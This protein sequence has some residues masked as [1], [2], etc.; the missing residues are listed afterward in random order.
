MQFRARQS[1]QYKLQNTGYN[2]EINHTEIRPVWHEIYPDNTMECLLEVAPT[3]IIGVDANNS[4]VEQDKKLAK[5]NLAWYGK[6]ITLLSRI[7]DAILI[8]DYP[9]PIPYTTAG[10]ILF[11][12]FLNGIVDEF[13]LD[14]PFPPFTRYTDMLYPSPTPLA[15]HWRKKCI[16]WL[17]RYL[18][19]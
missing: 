13:D 10:G 4:L 6:I 11:G 3:G 7:K 8:I 5:L 15:V 12:N 18:P 19:K 2:K 9:G 1:N 14:Q 16:D 17:P